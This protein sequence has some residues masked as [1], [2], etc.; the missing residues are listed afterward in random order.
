MLSQYCTLFRGLPFPSILPGGIRGIG[1][2]GIRGIWD[3]KERDIS[4]LSE[5]LNSSNSWRLS[6]KE[7]SIP[8][9]IMCPETE[10]GRKR[11]T[12]DFLSNDTMLVS[13]VLISVH[14]G[15]LGLAWFCILGELLCM[16][17]MCQLKGY[18]Q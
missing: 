6:P 14:L 17:G 9:P 13:L 15:N 10:H 18:V 16:Q 8:H 2:L 12:P 5:I 7:D 11:V 3:F 1:D 4:P